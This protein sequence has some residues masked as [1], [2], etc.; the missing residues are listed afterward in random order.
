[1]KKLLPIVCFLLAGCA[2]TEQQQPTNPIAKELQQAVAV[3]QPPADFEIPEEVADSLLSD[4]AA[5][6]EGFDPGAERFDIEVNDLDV[7]EFYRALVKDTPYNV[8]VHPDLQGVVSFDL[9]NVSLEE[10]MRLVRDIH[11]FE[12]KR[13]GNLFQVYPGGLKT[14]IFKVNYLS[15]N[16][17]GESEIRVSAGQVT[18]AGSSGG[19][20]D[21]NDNNRDN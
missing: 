18:N 7:H 6:A 1:M 12:Y 9:K 16:R 14:R 3:S 10:V 5:V 15:I 8:I 17:R 11:G 2:T 21:R 19:E 13:S 20:Q 4:F